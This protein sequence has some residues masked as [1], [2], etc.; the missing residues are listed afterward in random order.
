MAAATHMSGA[1]PEEAPRSQALAAGR[2]EPPEAPRLRAESRGSLLRHTIMNLAGLGLP[3]VVAVFTIPVLIRSLGEERFGLLTLIW[4]IVGYFGLFD[5]G[6][7]RALTQQLSVLIARDEQD[8]AGALVTTSLA[9]MAGLG[10]VAGIIIWAGAPWGVSLIKG[11]SDRQDAVS[12]LRSMAFAMPFIVLT[13]GLRGILEARFAFGVLNLIRIPMGLLTFLGP[14]AVVALWSRSLT[15]VA[16]ILTLGRIV[17]CAA[18]AWFVR[19]DL[20]AGG[21][22]REQLGPLLTSG[23]WLTVSNIISPLMGYADRFII[24]GTLSAGLVAYYTTPNEMITK[25]WII[26][27]ALTAVLFPRF[28]Q[29]IVR[30]GKDA[31]TLFRKAIGAVFLATLPIALAIAL[32]AQELLTLWVGAQFALHSAPILQVF[33]LG[34]VITCLAHLPYTAIQSANRARVTAL[35]HCGL[36]SVFVP[37]SWLLTQR[38]G[39]IGAV[40]TWLMRVIVDAALMFYWAFQIMGGRDSSGLRRKEVLVA[41]CS[42]L[43]FCGAL[44]SSLR[45][46]VALFALGLAV[47]TYA[48]KPFLTRLVG[49]AGWMASGSQLGTHVV[50]TP[51]TVRRS[52]Q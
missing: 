24:G 50:S 13:S 11:V 30:D 29:D 34:I 36:I 37:L 38:L 22:D 18:H 48:A 20:F 49:M 14:L 4:A 25:I 3:L 35:V 8:K 5:F 43:L 45:M 7:G 12:A 26:P 1:V 19:T 51:T 32:F 6:L 23:G 42:V 15:A 33:S 10:I 21:F 2:G 41:L 44:V 46:R 27:G 52:V 17:A 9:I 39:L 16:W 40:T 28:A 31:W 47:V